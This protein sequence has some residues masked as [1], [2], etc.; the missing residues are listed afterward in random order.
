MQNTRNGLIG[1]VVFHTIMLL[2]FIF[3]GFSTP[4]PLPAEEGILI[5]F[6][7]MEY[8]TGK[9]EPK[10]N[11]L[12]K[13]ESIKQTATSQVKRA[14]QNNMTQDF[15]EAPA[16]EKKSEKVVKEKTA[17]HKTPVNEQEKEKEPIKKPRKVNELALYKGKNDSKTSQ[18]EGITENQGNQGEETGSVSEQSHF[19][20]NNSGGGISFSLKG[21]YKLSLPEPEYEY[22]KEGKVVVEITVNR[23]GKVTNAIP[24]VKGST[25]LDTYLLNVAK[26]A[27][28]RAKFNT[29][30]DAPAF[31]KGTIT[32][33]FKLN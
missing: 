22:Q 13:K 4:L 6:G 23:E 27:A 16:I 8:G 17:D 12:E 2:I 10:R 20:G 25:T 30:S 3:W 1:T 28:L 5:N 33:I 21:R 14:E 18:G 19:I 26:K 29:K 7:N 24:G 15:E 9:T 31:Q 11:N 32:Y